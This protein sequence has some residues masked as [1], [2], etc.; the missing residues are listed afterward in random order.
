MMRIC[1]DVVGP[2]S[3]V[4]SSVTPPVA[5]TGVHSVL[6]ASANPRRFQLELRNFGAGNALL[7]AD[8][9]PTTTG[10]KLLNVDPA[11]SGH[12]RNVGNGLSL[13]GPAASAAFYAVSENGGPFSEVSVL[14]FIEGEP[15]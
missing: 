2:V 7:N 12:E 6:L 4:A 11:T 3:I 13:I 5:G 14:E 8:D 1:E 9:T 15:S 10:F